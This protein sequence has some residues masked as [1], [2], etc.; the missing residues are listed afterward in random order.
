MRASKL[1]FQR[2]TSLGRSGGGWGRV[3]TAYEEL[4]AVGH[5]PATLIAGA[6]AGDDVLTA[7]DALAKAAGDNEALL[8]AEVESLRQFGIFY[9]APLDLDWTMLQAYW[10]AYA[11]PADGGRGPQATDARPAVLGEDSRPDLYDAHAD[12]A[13]RW[14]RYLFLGRGKPAT[15]SRVLRGLRDDELRASVP[16][17]LKA[18]LTFVAAALAAPR[19]D[20]AG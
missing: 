4:L 15:H 12:E 3:R 10:N 7:V 5:V 2:N 19:P 17:E 9:C 6:K 14:Y 18:L 16:S 20:G 8:M 13:L 11:I 1:G